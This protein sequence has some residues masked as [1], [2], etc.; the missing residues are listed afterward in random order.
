[1]MLAQDAIAPGKFPH[2][3]VTKTKW[4]YLCYLIA[5]SEAKHNYVLRR[6]AGHLAGA[7]ILGVAWSKADTGMDLQ[8]PQ[9]V[10]SLIAAHTPA[11]GEQI[12]GDALVPA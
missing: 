2:I 10:L 7:Q 5:P 3:D 1:M 6:L 9:S 8:T 12:S 4:V 11:A